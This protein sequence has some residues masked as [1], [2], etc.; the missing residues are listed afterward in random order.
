[1]EAHLARVIDPAGGAW[2]VESLTDALARA[3]W[4]F[5]QEIEAAGGV[6]AALD[7]GLVA[8]AGRR[9]CARPASAPSPPAARR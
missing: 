1:M 4:A 6:V 9:R 8:D 2:F 3:G 7:A 5:F